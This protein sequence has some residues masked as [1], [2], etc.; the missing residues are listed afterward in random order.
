[1]SS[2]TKLEALQVLRALAAIGV[3]CFHGASL[4]EKFTGSAW[5]G[6]YLRP[7]VFGVDVFFVLSGFIIHFTGGGAGGTREFLL[8]RFIRLYPVYW[9]VLALL[10]AGFALAPNA[11]M[12]Q[13]GN[14]EALLSSALLWPSPHQILVVA[15]T[16]VFE[17]WFYLLYGLLFFRSRLLFYAALS[18]CFAVGC[19]KQILG[20]RLGSFALDA[21]MSPIVG[22]FLLGC[23]A[24]AL[25]ARFSGRGSRVALGVGA[26]GL[27]AAY[28]GEVAGLSF[29]RVAAFGV[30][31]ALLIY[32]AAALRWRWPR[33]LVFLGDASYS[34]YLL[35]E[36][37]L[38]FAMVVAIKAGWLAWTGEP[39]AQLAIYG[40]ILAVAALFHRM[41]EAPL[42]SA[43]RRR[44]LERGRQPDRD[45]VVSPEVGLARQ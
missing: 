38:S 13:H 43:C 33:P 29:S 39:M 45:M 7:G 15:W 21:F 5:L 17:V 35:H 14:F 26:A 2:G 44:W 34:L 18:A 19:A 20:I 28:A 25:F 36:P 10:L 4:F 42:L 23:V 22:E 11:Q 6:R 1:M 37:A 40:A 32:G 8:K 12:P 41:I 24:A 31:S 27:A 9:I 3:M 30:P 16:L